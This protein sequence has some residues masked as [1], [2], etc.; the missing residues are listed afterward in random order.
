MTMT[1]T[2]DTRFCTEQINSFIERQLA[3]WPVAATNFARLRDVKRK[4]LTIGALEIGIQFNPARIIST[5]A[6]IDTASIKQRPCFLCAS[7][8]D[9]LQFALDF[10]DQW[11]LLLNP[12]PIFPVHFTVAHKNHQLQGTI[13]LDMASMAEKASDLTLFY[14]GAHAGASAPDHQHAQAVLTSE[15][16]LMRLTEKTHTS[17][18]SS[19]MFSEETGLDLP[20][21]YVSM[22]ITPDPEGYRLLQRASEAFGVD[23]LTK[24]PD[25]G[26]LNA[27]FWMDNRGLLRI[28]IIPRKRHRP[29]CYGTADEHEFLISPGAIDMAGIIITPRQS[30]YDKIT[31]QDVRNIYADVAFADRLDESIIRHFKS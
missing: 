18:S 8:R 14:N 29:A 24:S 23:A 22:V 19:L 25:C 1:S 4:G 9:K 31:A 6:K 10:I 30:D 20:F 13:P 16:P 28:V 15:L 5:G 17:D 7:N 11:E 3:E 12:F 21:H 26:L 27:Y 2:N